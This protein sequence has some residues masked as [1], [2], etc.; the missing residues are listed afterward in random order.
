ML[1]SFLLFYV[2]GQQALGSEIING[3]EA[4]E[5]TLLYMAS[6]QVNGSHNC[7]GFLIRKDFVMTAAH[8]DGSAIN[9]KDNEQ[10]RVA[11]WGYTR[12]GGWTEDN[13]RVVDVSIINP[14]VCKKEWD[15]LPANVI[16]AGGYGTNKGFCQGD[17]GGPLVC[18]GKAVGVV[19]FNKYRNCNYPD[20]PNV[21]TDISKYLVWI[22]SVSDHLDHPH[23]LKITQYPMV[24]VIE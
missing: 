12:T 9:I 19:S 13:L 14:Q 6:L 7:G 24:C 11:G 22:N 15:G 17:S 4:P 10:C 20:V 3:N 16:C 1:H 23:T 18:S 2:L 5:N 21:Y 8:C